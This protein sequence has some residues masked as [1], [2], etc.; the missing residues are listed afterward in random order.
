MPIEI[1]SWVGERL[2]L[3]I[4]W[5]LLRGYWATHFFGKLLV[6][7]QQAEFQQILSDILLGQS[8]ADFVAFHFAPLVTS[9]PDSTFR[10][11]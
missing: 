5:F 2:N 9:W 3:E 6:E 1:S 8:Q 7:N 10:Y 11:S 4:A